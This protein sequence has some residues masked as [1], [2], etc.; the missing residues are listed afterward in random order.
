MEQ[1]A[2][3]L[4]NRV[5]PDTDG[6]GKSAA[7]LA[8]RAIWIAISFT[9]IALVAGLIAFTG[10]LTP[11][12]GGYSVG[13]IAGV[14]T[15][16][17]AGTSAI[18]GLVIATESRRGSLRWMRR[19]FWGWWLIDF[20]GLFILHGAIATMASLSIF[21]L[22][23]QAFQGLIVDAIAATAML[24]LVTAATSY[25]GFSSAS[26]ASSSS[27][28]TLLALF[29]AAGVLAS[30][31][32]AENPYWWH[33]FFSELG[34]RQAGVLSFWTFNT[35]ITVSGIV[36]TTLANFISQDLTAW[37]SHRQR[38]GKRRALVQVLR[39]GMIVMGICLIGLSWITIHISDPIHTG[40]VQILAVTFGIMLLSVPIWLPGAPAAMYVISYLMLGFGV[41]AVALWDPLGYYNLTALELAFAGIIF[42]W[43]VVL[44]RTLDAMISDVHEAKT[45]VTPPNDPTSAATEGAFFDHEQTQDR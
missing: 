29:M 39:I 20:I 32:L 16:V 44:I 26:R 11:L 25:F 1:V 10:R 35:T 17:A 3:E 19:R 15:G 8:S 21:R 34:T 22:F 33:Q 13:T 2:P 43:L 12:S 45:Q 40:F 30:M 27:I 38:Q 7:H 18:I 24:C 9:A 4:D 23:Q 37:A 5:V 31:L 36:L 28:S 14:M 42:A 6:T 41:F